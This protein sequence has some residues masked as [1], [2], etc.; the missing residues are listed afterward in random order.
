LTKE[1]D[2]CCKMKGAFDMKTMNKEY[3]ILFNEITDVSEE[4]V[5]LT[6]D[7]SNVVGRLM[8]AQQRTEEMFIEEEMEGKDSFDIELIK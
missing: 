1:E 3:S 6:N 5:K 8:Y 4:L 7:L 2:G